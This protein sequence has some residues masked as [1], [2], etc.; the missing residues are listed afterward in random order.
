MSPRSIEKANDV[1][2]IPAGRGQ[3]PACRHCTFKPIG[4]ETVCVPYLGVACAGDKGRPV[5]YKHVVEQ[6]TRGVLRVRSP[7]DEPAVETR[8]AIVQLV[9]GFV[10]SLA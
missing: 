3:P 5:I 4:L 10:D 6:A 7:L 9:L 2:I 8:K 1:L